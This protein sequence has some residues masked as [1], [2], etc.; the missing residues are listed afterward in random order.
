M[1]GDPRRS[2]IYDRINA[3]DRAR[4]VQDLVRL[5]KPILNA[6]ADDYV[7]GD[8]SAT[9][10]AESWRD[11]LNSA[12]HDEMGSEAAAALASAG[13]GAIHAPPPR[14]GARPS[15]YGNLPASLRSI[16]EGTHP[17]L[18]ED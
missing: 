13:G 3:L 11:Q 15:G 9:A 1:S 14:P 2:K 12:M 8:A 7:A 6:L 5:L 4:N 10:Y 17:S 16:A 18:R